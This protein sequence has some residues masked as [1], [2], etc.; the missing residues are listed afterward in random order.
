MSISILDLNGLIF[1]NRSESKANSLQLKTQG[2]VIVMTAKYLSLLN[3]D[4]ELILE[5][6]W[7]GWKDVDHRALSP[8]LPGKEVWEE[9]IAENITQQRSRW[10][11]GA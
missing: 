4:N 8:I 2:Q 7:A 5:L 9:N 3:P 10:L 1:L 6:A 11:A